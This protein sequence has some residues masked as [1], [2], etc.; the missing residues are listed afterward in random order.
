MTSSGAP[1]RA[2]GGDGGGSDAPTVAG[3]DADGNDE[4][5]GSHADGERE[6]AEEAVAE[7]LSTFHVDRVQTTGMVAEKLEV[8]DPRARRLLEALCERDRLTMARSGTGV[9][10]WLRR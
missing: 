1:R 5:G 2:R 3:A 4:S 6:L 8:D 7:A 9:P 10:V